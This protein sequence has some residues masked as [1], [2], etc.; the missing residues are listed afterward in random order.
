MEDHRSPEFFHFLDDFLS[1]VIVLSFDG[2]FLLLFKYNQSWQ[3]TLQLLYI[4]LDALGILESMLVDSVSF[5][6][7]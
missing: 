3:V 7:L 5:D 4:F 2:L 1:S 6:L